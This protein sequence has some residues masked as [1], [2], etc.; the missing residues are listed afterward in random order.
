MSSYTG[1]RSSKYAGDLAT[2]RMLDREKKLEAILN[3]KETL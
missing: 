2:G 3:N 1:D